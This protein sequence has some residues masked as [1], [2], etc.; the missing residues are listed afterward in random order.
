MCVVKV[1]TEERKRNKT[2]FIWRPCE[3]EYKRMLVSLICERDPLAQI[4]GKGLVNEEFPCRG[5]KDED[6]E[7]SLR[8]IYHEG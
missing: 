6:V 7:D 1:N 5:P 8:L 4:Y 2:K 3:Q